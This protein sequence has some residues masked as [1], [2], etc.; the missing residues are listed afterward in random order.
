[1][2]DKF[3]QKLFEMAEQENMIVPDAV[4]TKVEDT[5]VGVPKHKGI[6]RMNWKKSL[7]L[8]AAC[9]MMFSITVSATV[10]VLRERMEAM[11]EQEMEEYFANIYTAKIGADTYN[12]PYT[13]E[14]KARMKE[15]RVSYEEAG[16]FPEKALK[17][18][19]A[20]QEY[21]GSGVAFFGDTATFFLPDGEM[22]DEELLQIID[23][24][25]KRDYS[26]MAINEKIASGEM[27]FPEEAVEKKAPEI[28]A[29]DAD[30]LSS[31]AIW[32]PE[33]ELTISYTGS[34]EATFMAA[35]QDCIFLA[36]NSVIHKMEIGSSD[37]T[38]FFD[39]FGV[40]TYVNA[41]YQDKSG[42][43]ILGLSQLTQDDKYHAT[44]A[45]EHYNAAVWILSSA[46]EVKQKIDLSEYTDNMMFGVIYKIAADDNGY[47]YVK[48]Y[49]EDSH[50][51]LMVF[52]K[53]G[54][55]VTNITSD[56]YSS[57]PAGG[58]GVG[59]DGKVYVEINKSIQ[60]E[61]G[62][63]AGRIMGIASVNV[64]KS[65]LEDI[66]AGIVPEN[67]IMIDVIA[68]GAN[69]DFV[70]WGYD[71]IYT[72]NLGDE[73]VVNVLPAYEAPCDW[74]GVMKCALPDGRIVFGERGEYRKV[75]GH[76]VPVPEKICFYYKSGM[77][78]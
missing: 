39:D 64:E 46:G 54:N 65:C 36:G 76:S 21:N 34:L 6:F 5:L 59:K 32:D 48:T 52:D 70:F 25:Y 19:S 13:A 28:E 71:G 3:E 10:G 4:Y 40:K 26:L 58:L 11:N 9:V 66:Y 8:A 33:Q 60:D 29:T 20:P 75:D 18:I 30:V 49:L 17:M 16:L 38:L 51:F 27:E 62:E 37:S 43:I 31:D 55:F 78:K 53:E 73:S 74:E 15:L 22:S 57:H 56:E 69:T 41:L 77:R 35:G 63:F 44:I 45:G 47:I 50:A 67:F 14:E 72:Y 23:F 2:S 1:M 42:D 68:P 24:M 7:V 12:R 61:N